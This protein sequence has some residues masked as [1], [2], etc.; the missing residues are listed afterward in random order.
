MGF[1][2]F[3]FMNSGAGKRLEG[4]K[5]ALKQKLAAARAENAALR[6]QLKQALRQTGQPPPRSP[7]LEQGLA[8][9]LAQLQ[10]AADAEPF[11]QFREVTGRLK[12]AT[13]EFDIMMMKSKPAHYLGAGISAMQAMHRGIPGLAEQGP[14]RILDFGCGYGRVARFM[15]AAWPEAVLRVCDVDF[16]G[17]AFCLS[18]L[19]MEGFQVGTDPRSMR[20]GSGYDL[21][22][23]GSVVTHLDAQLIK[24]LLTAL[25]AALAPGGHVCFTAHGDRPVQKLR[26]GQGLYDLTA[27]D[28]A[29]VV[30]GYEK[31]GFGYADYPN[32]QGY[33]VS[34]TSRDWLQRTVSEIPGL[35]WQDHQPRGWDNHQDVVVCRRSL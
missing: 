19:G 6:E 21:I 26:D 14:A 1:R 11:P 5:T 13:S 2:S 28:A 7:A 9:A 3:L 4:D 8:A 25:C 17:I 34:A 15:Q 32:Q 33:G 20:L 30:A 22:W 16:A 18:H 27:E 35:Q 31:D 10:S 29:K 23:V 12:L 24:D